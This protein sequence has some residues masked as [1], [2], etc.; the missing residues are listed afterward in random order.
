MPKTKT[1]STRNLLFWISAGV[2]IILLWSLLQPTGGAKKPL[3]FSQFMSEVE[4]GNVQDV[5]IQDNDLS[6]VY[7]D[8]QTFKTVLPA[9]YSDIYKTLIASKVNITVK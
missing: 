9:A 1:K 5:T 3:T 2:V 8:G 7:K 6:G 4:Q